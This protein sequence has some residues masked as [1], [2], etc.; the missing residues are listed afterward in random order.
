MWESAGEADMRIHRV[1]SNPCRCSARR[2]GW[3]EIS[4]GDGLAGDISAGDRLA[5][6]RLVADK[7]FAGKLVG[8][9]LVA[10]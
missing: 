10:V 9:R 8:G 3:E 7:L 6:E 2:R 5:A 4:S 1:G